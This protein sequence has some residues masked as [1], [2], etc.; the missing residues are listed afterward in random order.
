MWRRDPVGSN[1]A[2]EQTGPCRNPALASNRQTTPRAFTGR[3]QIFA[4]NI[5][6]G[7]HS[8]VFKFS[9]CIGEAR[10]FAAGAFYFYLKGDD[11]LFS[12]SIYR[13]SS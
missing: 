4:R 8:F 7:T 10:I 9:Y 1:S 5:F 13:L 3:R 6:D 12:S 2:L 11:L